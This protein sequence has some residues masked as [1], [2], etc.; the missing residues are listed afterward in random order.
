MP[1]PIKVKS[2]LEKDKCFIRGLK[3]EIK[4]ITRNLGIQETVTL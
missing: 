2:C 3:P 1:F 4:Q